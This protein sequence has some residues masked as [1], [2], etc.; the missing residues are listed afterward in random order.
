MPLVVHDMREDPL[1]E[2]WDFSE[3]GSAEVDL[4]F[5]GVPIKDR[6]RVVGTLTIDRER[7]RSSRVRLD[8]DVRF[9]VMVANLMGQTGLELCGE[10]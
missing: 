6:G 4:A 10:K 3:W 1:F 2:S 7:S 8:E 9:L 5:V